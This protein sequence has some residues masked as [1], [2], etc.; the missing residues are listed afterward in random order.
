MPKYYLTRCE[1]EVMDVV[2]E[3]GKATVQDVC[4]GLERDLAYTTVMTTLKVL[5]EKRKVLR[6]TKQG[7]A[8]LY[9]PIVSREDVGRSV[10]ADLKEKLFRGSA[11]SLVL[12]LMEDEELSPSDIDELKSAIASLEER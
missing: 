12:S 5:E 1:L 4:D 9:E 11:K 10:T 7:R 3:R 2:W 8:Y 6:R